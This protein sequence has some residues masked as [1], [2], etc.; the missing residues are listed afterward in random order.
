M[1]LSFSLCCSLCV[2]LSPRFVIISAWLGKLEEPGGKKERE[3]ARKKDDVRL[4]VLYV[5]KNLCACV[6]LCVFMRAS[7]CEFM[8]LLEGCSEKCEMG[9]VMK[10]HTIFPFLF[11]FPGGGQT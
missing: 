11:C 7:V 2:F 4:C 8:S 1:S 9:K 3:R 5:F 10:V 6:C